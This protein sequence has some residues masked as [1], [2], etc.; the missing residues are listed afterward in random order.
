MRVLVTGSAGFIATNLVDWLD[1][2]YEL[3][4][5]DVRLLGDVTDIDDCMEMSK[6]VDCIVHLAAL[7]GV[8]Q[9]FKYPLQTF[10]T[11]V[12]GT[13]NIVEAAIANEVPKIIL[14]SSGAADNK[15]S[16]PYAMS[17]WLAEYIVQLSQIG[18]VILRFSNVY[19]PYSDHKMSLVHVALRALKNG[20]H[21]EVYG[22]GSHSRDFIHVN[23]VCRAIELAMLSNDKYT[24]PLDIGTGKATSVM[25]VLTECA[26]V[27]NKHID[28]TYQPER[29]EQ[30]RAV[31]NTERAFRELGFRAQIGLRDGLILT[32]EACQ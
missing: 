27:A 25:D 30:I 19:G 8:P 14:A 32:W 20:Q 15:G 17:K 21:I 24:N 4:G 18:A 26:I 13:A 11:N 6:G 3:V 7:P 16:S 29:D 28:V 5:M 1:G 31:A 23:D 22:D 10:R 2:R 9:S 12:I